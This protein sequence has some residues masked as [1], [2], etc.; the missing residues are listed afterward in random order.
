MHWEQAAR[1]DPS[2]PAYA[3]NLAW[4][5]AISPEPDLPRALATIDPVVARYPNDPRFRETRGQ[6]L[7]KLGRWK[8][9]LP[10]LQSALLV[11]SGSRELHRALAATYDH[12]EAPGMAAEHRRRADQPPGTKPR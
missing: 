9:A 12:L 4:A 8:D 5:L 2:M 7:A 3:N 10:D 1:L 6:V 11:Y